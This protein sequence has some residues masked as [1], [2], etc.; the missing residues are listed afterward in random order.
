MYFLPEVRGMGLGS[1]LLEFILEKAKQDNYKQ[2]YLETMY[3][4][5]KAN[6]LYQ[7]FSFKKLDKPL[8]DTR[9]TWTT[10]WYMKELTEG[11]KS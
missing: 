3:F 2:C 9:H 11:V 8:I 7:K 10:N 5:S 6:A 1:R 4:M